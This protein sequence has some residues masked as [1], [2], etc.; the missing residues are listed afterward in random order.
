MVTSGAQGNCTYVF[1]SGYT[2]FI[3]IYLHIYGADILV[4]VSMQSVSIKMRMELLQFLH[5]TIYVMCNTLIRIITRTQPL[6]SVSVFSLYLI[7]I[8]EIVISQ[9]HHSPSPES[10]QL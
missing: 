6:L 7:L 5:T 3:F 4:T 2:K 8:E 10:L 9:L 1:Q